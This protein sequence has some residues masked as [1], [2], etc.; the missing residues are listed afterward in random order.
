[1]KIETIYLKPDSLFSDYIRKW[2]SELGIN[3]VEHE[4][5]IGDQEA[6]GLLLINENQDIEKEIN[7]I[8]SYFDEK[9]LPTQ[10]IDIN[11][12]LQVAMSNI[13]LWLKNFKCKKIF[14]VGSDKL[15]SNENLDRLLNRINEKFVY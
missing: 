2:A 8:H 10:K 9:H 5:K 7:V 1:M 13:D 14:I 12:T 11:G 3:V 15:M 6:D 4:F